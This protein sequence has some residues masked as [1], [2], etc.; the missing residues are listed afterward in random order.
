[1]EEL[2]IHPVAVVHR[3]D[4]EFPEGE[5]VLEVRPELGPAML[6]LEPG[7]RV[8][9]MWWMHRLDEEQRGTL[10]CHPM[11]DRSEPKRGVFALRSPMRPNPIGSSVVDVLEVRGNEL[12]VA[13]LDAFD[14][15]PVVDIKI[16]RKGE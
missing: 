12:V 4:D 2:T 16:A 14:G 8:Q 15:S 1:M 11:G 5:C 3:D 6:G 10:Q 13:G 9:V 7:D